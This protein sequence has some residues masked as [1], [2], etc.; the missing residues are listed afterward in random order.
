MTE[1]FFFF[2]VFLN[3]SPNGSDILQKKT[4]LCPLLLTGVTLPVFEHYQEGG[5]SKSY[6]FSKDHDDNSFNIDILIVL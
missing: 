1:M 5:D 4:H 3:V 6:S 2:Y